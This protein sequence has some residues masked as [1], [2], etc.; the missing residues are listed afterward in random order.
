MF[1]AVWYKILT[2]LNI[3]KFTIQF[4]QF[5]SKF[6]QLGVVNYDAC[7][8]LEGLWLVCRV[9]FIRVFYE[10]CLFISAL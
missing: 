7:I 5:V 2:G 10:M 1:T 9:R 3:D 4:I 8:L 6:L